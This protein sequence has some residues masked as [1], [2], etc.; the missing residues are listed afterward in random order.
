MFM[1]C[2]VPMLFGAPVAK[3]VEVNLGLPVPV[4]AAAAAPNGELAAA[5]AP[6]AGAVTPALLDAAAAAPPPPKEKAG[7]AAAAPNVGWLVAAALD[8]PPPPK[9]KVGVAA[10]VAAAPKAGAAGEAAAAAPKAGAAG[11]AAAAASALSPPPNGLAAAPNAGAAGW[12]NAGAAGLAAGPPAPPKLNVGVDAGAAPKPAAGDAAA[13][14]GLAAAPP[15]NENAGD[16]AGAAAPKAGAA[17]LALAP[18]K[19]NAGLLCAAAPNEKAIRTPP[20]ARVR[21]VAAAAVPSYGKGWGA[22]RA[23]SLAPDPFFFQRHSRIAPFDFVKATLEN[24]G[25][26]SRSRHGLTGP[27]GARHPSPGVLSQHRA[28]SMARP[29][30]LP[31]LQVVAAPLPELLCSEL[32]DSEPVAGAQ[33]PGLERAAAAG[34]AA[35][36]CEQ[37]ASA[38]GRRSLARRQQARGHRQTT[39]AGVAS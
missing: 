6:K 9:L 10:A 1:E 38:R 15:P 3:T 8:A 26:F 20:R 5:A 7:A 13:G 27:P 25:V 35:R 4:V 39:A 33:Q 11:E 16:A 2:S 14:A 34:R 28:V 21:A 23:S 22:E 24:R 37:P 31:P 32:A 12:P 30:R 29:F 19:L 18:P 36:V 17:G